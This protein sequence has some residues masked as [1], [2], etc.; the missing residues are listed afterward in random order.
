MN[1]EKNKPVLH[2]SLHKTQLALASNNTAFLAYAREH[3]AALAA[4]A[5]GAPDIQ[6]QLH[7]DQELTTTPTI[8][9]GYRRLSRRLLLDEDNI[10]QTEILNLPGLQLQSRL[11]GAGLSIDASFCPPSKRLRLILKLGN[12]AIQER[13]YAILIYYLAY[14][15]LLWRLERHEQRHPLHA[16]AIAWP[17]GAAI[18]AGL[19]G[20]GKSTLTLAFLSDPNARLLSENLILHDGK[21]VFSF[22]EPIHLDERSHK[23]L[24]NLDGR[25]EPTGR[26]Y[27]HNRQSYRLGPSALAASATPRM[28]CLLRQG[29]KTELKPL[30]V[31]KALELTISSDLLAKEL[32]AYFQQ[33]AVLN[34]LSPSVGEFQRRIDALQELLSRVDCYELT[35]K[36]GQDLSR[37]TDLVRSKL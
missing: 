9:Q 1:S 2:L 23:L 4:P 22:L 15:P 21:Q 25:L 24:P 12:K 31:A 5:P 20:V 35:I 32:D 36:P 29:Q 27:S 30:S 3:L 18:L 8:A 13:I 19:G 37:A 17:Q 28:F 10:I 14:F 33:A 7:W 16:S 6:V 26:I 34:L 11:V